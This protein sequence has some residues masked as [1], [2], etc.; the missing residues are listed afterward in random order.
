MF[1]SYCGCYGHEKKDCW[2]I[3]GFPDWW[4]E[5]A[6]QSNRGRVKVGEDVVI[7]VAALEEDKLQQRA[8]TP[9][10]SLNSLM[11]NGEF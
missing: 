2:Q 7:A 6:E 11:I 9:L 8:L 3:V 10:F 5:Q 4:N 1:C